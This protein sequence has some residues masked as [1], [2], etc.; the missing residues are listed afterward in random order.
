VNIYESCED[1]DCVDCDCWSDCWGEAYLLYRMYHLL[2][3]K[4]GRQSIEK[5]ERGD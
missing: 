1:Y 4:M 2:E 3:F 5:V